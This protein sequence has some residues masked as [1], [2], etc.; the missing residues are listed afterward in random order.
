MS[1]HV[2]SWGN[3]SQHLRHMPKVRVMFWKVRRC[4]LLTYNRT[5]AGAGTVPDLS[6]IHKNHVLVPLSGLA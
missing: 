2:V 1:V 5:K 6:H 3:Q 4:V